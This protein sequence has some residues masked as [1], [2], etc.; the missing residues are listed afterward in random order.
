MARTINADVQG[1]L[2]P[3]D[4]AGRDKYGDAFANRLGPALHGATQLLLGV[5]D[6]LNKTA[7]SRSQPTCTKG[8]QTWPPILP[9]A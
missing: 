2:D 4:D 1:Q 7:A 8:Q 9:L 5:R 3:V 6:G